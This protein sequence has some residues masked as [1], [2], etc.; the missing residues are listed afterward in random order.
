MFLWKESWTIA[1]SA[2][3]LKD[4]CT[5]VTF[6]DKVHLTTTVDVAGNTQTGDGLET[7]IPTQVHRRRSQ[8]LCRHQ[9][10][11]QQQQHGTLAVIV[12]RMMICHRQTWR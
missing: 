12:K 7:A 2:T 6:A 1:R 10:L 9:C 11:C 8:H 5:S 4:D 3:R